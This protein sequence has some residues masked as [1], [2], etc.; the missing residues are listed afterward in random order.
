MADDKQ[1]IVGIDIGKLVPG[2]LAAPNEL[3]A[4]VTKHWADR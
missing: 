2:S 4:L 3:P 1:L